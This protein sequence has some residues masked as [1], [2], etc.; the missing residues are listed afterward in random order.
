MLGGCFGDFLDAVVML[1]DILENWGVL[2]AL[3]KFLRDLQPNRKYE[4][5]Q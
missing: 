1:M 3:S 5:L 2:R 4:F